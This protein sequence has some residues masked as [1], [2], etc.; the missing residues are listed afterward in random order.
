MA[1]SW[2]IVIVTPSHNIIKDTSQKKIAPGR[3][4]RQV[5]SKTKHLPEQQPRIRLP[6]VLIC[7]SNTTAPCETAVIRVISRL[8]L[9]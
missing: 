7:P 4:Y 9:K 3:S 5:Q 2:H 1:I 6:D 8:N